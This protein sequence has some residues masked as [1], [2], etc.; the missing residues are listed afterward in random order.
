M[1]YF[2]KANFKQDSFE[3]KNLIFE[4][5]E[6]NQGPVDYSN[7]DVQKIINNYNNDLYNIMTNKRTNKLIVKIKNAVT[8]LFTDQDRLKNSIQY[9]FNQIFKKKD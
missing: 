5:V 8:L 3:F 7:K 4:N 2:T 1:N 9:K 6:E